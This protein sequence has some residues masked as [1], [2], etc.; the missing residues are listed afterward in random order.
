MQKTWVDVTLLIENLREKGKRVDLKLL[1]QIVDTDN[2][3]RFSFDESFE[4]IRANQGHS[5]KMDLGYKVQQPPGTL[6]HGTAKKLVGSI[7]KSG[8]DKRNRN[9]VHLSLDIESALKVGK[10]HGDPYVFKVLAAQMFKDDFDFYL[11]K[12]GVWL[13]DKVPKKY[14]N[15]INV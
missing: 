3:N 2:K 7:L 10:R 8:L 15:H 12:N 11:S 1:K 6:Y 9:H 5:V 13:T 4:K 14:L